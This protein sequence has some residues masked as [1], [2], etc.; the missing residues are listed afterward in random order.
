MKSYIMPARR[1]GEAARL[2]RWLTCAS[3]VLCVG[4]APVPCGPAT[5]YGAVGDGKT[6]NDRALAAALAACSSA[7]GGRVSLTTADAAVT[8]PSSRGRRSDVGYSGN[9]IGSPSTRPLA[10][11]V[12]HPPPPPSL[13]AGRL[14]FATRSKRFLPIVRLRRRGQDVTPRGIA[15][16]AGRRRYRPPTRARWSVEP[17]R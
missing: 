9:D 13:A 4:G 15:Q 17:R 12:F 8:T 16:E 3:S 7:G 2:A 14:L 5:A 6:L 10:P 1:I 11:S